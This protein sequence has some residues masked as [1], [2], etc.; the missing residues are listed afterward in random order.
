MQDSSSIDGKEAQF[1]KKVKPGFFKAKGAAEKG[2]VH[3]STGVNVKPKAKRSK[4]GAAAAMLLKRY[5]TK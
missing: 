1:I 3:G 5:A 2:G 4:V